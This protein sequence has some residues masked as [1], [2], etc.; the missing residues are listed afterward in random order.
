M[1]KFKA[2]FV[3]VSVATCILPRITLANNI[4]NKQLQA[5]IQ[6]IVNQKTKHLQNEVSGLQSQVRTLKVQLRQ[7]RQQRRTPSSHRRSQPSRYRKPTT[8]PQAASRP[9][10]ILRSRP[11]YP[12][13]G[14][15]TTVQ[16]QGAKNVIKLPSA[17]QA[18]RKT[19]LSGIYLGGTPVFTS[20]YIGLNSSYD[21]SDLIVNAPKVN[22]DVRLL[23]QADAMYRSIERAGYAVPKHPVIEISGKVEG[24]GTYGRASR[25][26]T[27]ADA[28]LSSAE[29]DTFAQIDQYV[30]GYMAFNFDDSQLSPI[31]TSNSRIF[32]DRGFIT[33][34]DFNRQPWYLSIGQMYVPF[35]QYTNYILSEPVT[36]ALGRIQTRALSIGI[37]PMNSNGLFAAVY[38][39]RGNVRTDGRRAGG[40]DVGIQGKRGQVDGQL[41]FSATSNIAESQGMQNNGQDDIPFLGFGANIAGNPPSGLGSERLSKLVPAYDIQGTLDLYK[42][43]LLAEYVGTFRAFARQDLTFN[44]RGAR[45]KALHVELIRHFSLFG[46]PGNMGLTYGYTDQALS[47]LLPRDRF[48]A[49]FNYSYWRNTIESIEIRHD[50][51]YPTSDRATGLVTGPGGIPMPS[52]PFGF[53]RKN[54]T[55][56]TGQL[57]VYF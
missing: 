17:Q 16:G 20:P 40:F 54:D 18:Q 33:V 51:N 12:S 34:G 22:L 38:G 10:P 3:A 36:E 24:Q 5:M 56:I 19:V 52:L 55:L 57:G 47:L 43:S 27:R 29:F 8:Y 31:R 25:R 28:T 26:S 23:R 46:R 15:R 50:I 37:R 1:P 32:L 14:V 6:K 39:F 48:V 4:S 45:P 11:N 7:A 9:R 30:F 49:I 35:G 13:P 44:G 53:N 42:Y 21:G 41:S 2:L